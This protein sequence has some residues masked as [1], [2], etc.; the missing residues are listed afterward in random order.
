MCEVVA[1]RCRAAWTKHIF[2]LILKCEALSIWVYV[3]VI[4][5]IEVHMIEPCK[6]IFEIYMR[7]HA[8]V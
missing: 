1:L 2:L 7:D 8:V 5:S 3:Y 6:N 4:L